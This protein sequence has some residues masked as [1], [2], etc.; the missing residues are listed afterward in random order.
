MTYNEEDIDQLLEKIKRFTITKYGEYIKS[1]HRFTYPT[2][3]CPH[4]ETFGTNPT[5]ISIDPYN[6][7]LA[8]D[9]IIQDIR[10]IISRRGPLI[11]RD[12][13][14]EL[15][16][17]PGKIAGAIAYRLC[18]KHI[19]HVNNLCIAQPPCKIRCTTKLNIGLALYCGLDFIQLQSIQIDSLLLREL[20]Y[21]VSSR[22]VNQ[23][24]LGLFFDTIRIC[25]NR[26]NC[27][28]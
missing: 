2:A 20:F 4:N 26:A 23:E 27:N 14:N 18:R 1:Y 12:T 21:Q 17:S 16:I 11:S 25:S 10:F 28:V 19:I 24:T 15:R 9:E 5:Q 6:L 13:N 3:K 22:H 7:N 8:I